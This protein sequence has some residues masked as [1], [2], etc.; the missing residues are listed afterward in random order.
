MNDQSTHYE[1]WVCPNMNDNTGEFGIG[2]GPR[3]LHAG[4]LPWRARKLLGCGA[5]RFRPVSSGL[6]CW[7][8][9]GDLGGRNNTV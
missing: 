3:P 2:A 4:G 1:G 6:G 5:D 9:V 7:R 8:V